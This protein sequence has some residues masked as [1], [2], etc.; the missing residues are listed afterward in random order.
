MLTEP[1]LILQEHK[2]ANSMGEIYRTTPDDNTNKPPVEGAY[3]PDEPPFIFEFVLPIG[4]ELP[5]GF[6]LPIEDP[7]DDTDD[8]SGEV[9]N[10]EAA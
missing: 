6:K 2:G 4:F 8:L 9:G 1:L 7:E 5:I 10:N 3:A